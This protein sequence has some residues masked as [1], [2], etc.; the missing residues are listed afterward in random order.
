MERIK[1]RQVSTNGGIPIQ[2]S[3]I[4]VRLNKIRFKVCLMTMQWWLFLGTVMA[5]AL[6]LHMG[7]LITLPGAST[8]LFFVFGLFLEE[9]STLKKPL[10]LLKYPTV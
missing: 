7:K 9:N 8:F 5:R 6:L 3:L 4:K 2:V 10:Q 1:L